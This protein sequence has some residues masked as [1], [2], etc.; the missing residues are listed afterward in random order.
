M[1]IIVETCV[2]IPLRYLHN[3]G[4]I[5]V[6]YCGGELP[7]CGL[8]FQSWMSQ[9]LDVG[10]I[11]IGEKRWQIQ[12]VSTAA[13][14]EEGRRWY[15]LSDGKRFLNLLV[16]GNR[17]G[18]RLDLCAHYRCQHQKSATRRTKKRRR[19][20]GEL[21]LSA[22]PKNMNL[23]YSPLPP[24]PPKVQW[25]TW[26]RRH[27]FILGVDQILVRRPDHIALPKFHRLLNALNRHHIRSGKVEALSPTKQ[28]YRRKNVS[29]RDLSEAQNGQ[30]DIADWNRIM[31]KHQR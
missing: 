31:R 10:W 28:G 17:I 25:V 6:G 15:L 7:K 5:R 12:T 1:S 14:W 29:L 19:I 18:T 23:I 2:S 9:S 11:R 4:L 24:K 3:T 8:R 13:S 30:V 16:V 20:L 22:D 26:E 21:G 27:R